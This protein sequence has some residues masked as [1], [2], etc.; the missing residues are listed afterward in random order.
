LIYVSFHRIVVRR[1]L[2]VAM[3]LR[4]FRADYEPRE[5]RFEYA[6]PERHE[7]DEL[8]AV[9]DAIDS[10]RHAL[11]EQHRQLAD[12]YALSERLVEE[13]TH[14]LRLSNQTLERQIHD[15]ERVKAELTAASSAKM[16]LLGNMSH[17]IRTPIS[18]IIG[19]SGLLLT[20]DLGDSEREY[21]R[22]INESGSSLLAIVEDLLDLSRLESDRV[23]IQYEPVNLRETVSSVVNIL[24]PSAEQQRCTVTIRIDSSLPELFVTDGVRLQQ[25][26]RNL[27]SNAIKFAPDGTV[28]V[29][30]EPVAT[31]QGAKR[32]RIAVEDSGIGIR[33]EDLERIFESFFQVDGSYAK[34]FS[35]TGLGLAITRRLVDLMGG[36]IRVTSTLG[37]GSTFAV[38]LPLVPVEP[39]PQMHEAAPSS[40]AAPHPDG[41]PAEGSGLDPLAGARILLA[42]DNAINRLYIGRVLEG[43]GCEVTEAASG[44]AALEA[45]EREVPDLVLMDIQMPGLD[46]V[47]TTRRI[48]ASHDVPIVALTA[49]ARQE[50]LET[51]LSAGMDAVVTKP[52]SE[53]ELCETMRR[54]LVRA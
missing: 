51:F 36:S 48:R 3:Y 12:A 54:L 44:T 38:E 34:E 22:A 52:V 49:Y 32:L 1:I 11:N 24:S 30:A 28:V 18:G 20:R 46:G 21:V 17:E 39:A 9:R 27:L 10:L 41:E 53:R 4:S 16:M 19:L 8:D 42:E 33:E 26:L 37:T 47:E 5:L 15:L 43:Y 40:R 6:D 50:E 45:V 23:E 14:E 7:P 2:E 35:G 29:S 13:K 25:V 31:D